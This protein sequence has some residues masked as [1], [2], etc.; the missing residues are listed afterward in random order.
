MSLYMQL[1][2][3]IPAS[4]SINFV[5]K[6]VKEQHKIIDKYKFVGFTGPFQDRDIRK[7]QNKLN[8]NGDVVYIIDILVPNWYFVVKPL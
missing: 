1:P 4:T 6:K 2:I 3:H 8:K 7:I 5:V